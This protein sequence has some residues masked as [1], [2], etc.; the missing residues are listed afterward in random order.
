M[1]FDQTVR[2]EN[3]EKLSRRRVNQLGEAPWNINPANNRRQLG[4]LDL[5]SPGSN[6][7]GTADSISYSERSSLLKLLISI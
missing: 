6:C 5:N 4:T 3:F 1:L 7:R 2:A